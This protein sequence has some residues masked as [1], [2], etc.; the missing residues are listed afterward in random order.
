MTSCPPWKLGC[1]S[2]S[3]Q[4]CLMY[5]EDNPSFPWKK[6][7]KITLIDIYFPFYH[8]E[9]SKHCLIIL[10]PKEHR[11][12][13]QCMIFVQGKDQMVLLSGKFTS[14]FV[15]KCYPFIIV[16]RSASLAMSVVF[17]FHDCV[18]TLPLLG[19]A[20][21]LYFFHGLTLLHQL[22]TQAAGLPRAAVFQWLPQF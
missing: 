7:E 9:S 1:Q 5:P 16:L 4:N 17:F 3:G 19:R 14:M 8:S 18:N 10:F 13:I 6:L 12:A 22:R 11:H 20:L 21:C 15:S 2:L